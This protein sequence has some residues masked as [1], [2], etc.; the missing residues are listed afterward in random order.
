M[1]YFI[2]LFFINNLSILRIFKS[3]AIRGAVAFFISLFIMLIFG[4]TFINYLRKKKM[5]DT[6]REEGPSTHFSKAGTPTMG[7]IMIIFS[8]IVSMLISG[9]FTNKFT[10]FLV[11]M[12]ILFTTIGAYDDYLKLT[13][14]K[15]GLSG[16]KKLI[17][18][19]IMTLITYIFVYHFG[20]VNKTIDFAIINPFIKLSYL[21]IGPIVFLIFMAIVILGSSNAVN[22]TDG[23]DGLVSGPIMIVSIIFLM[24]SY[25][26]GH[27]EL[28]Q[29]L[30]I[31]YIEGAGEIAVYLSSVIGAVIGFL[32]YNFYP[33][34]VFMGD[35]G[36]LTL[37]GILGMIAIFVK[38]EL[39]L[40]I[41]GFVFIMEAL[42][43]II[44]VGYYKKYK[45]RI[46]R[47]A[48]IHHHFEMGGLAET[49][50]T[51]RFWIVTIITCIIAFMILKI[52]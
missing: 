50:V 2:Q 10:I 35:T 26:T 46:F 47:M 52:R 29:Y 23:L 32:W 14:S 48:P 9:N 37:G 13:K 41:A 38:Q 28:A 36:S 19:L 7:G 45:K 39:L 5:G 30:N 21:Y 18:Q 3:I 8:I 51:I 16:R 34:Q 4:Q 49:K 6:I 11:L 22:L 25:F 43:V 40:P 1:L 24:V 27:K 17:G 31:Y 20:L 15:N 44:Q 12:T 33:A 42:S